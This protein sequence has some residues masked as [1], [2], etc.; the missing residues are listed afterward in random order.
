[1]MRPIH[2]RLSALRLPLFYL[3]ANTWDWLGK[4][5]MRVHRENETAFFTSPRVRGERLS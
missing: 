3:E 1:M 2:L 4:T 5:R